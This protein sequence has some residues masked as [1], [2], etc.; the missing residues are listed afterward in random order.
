MDDYLISG[1]IFAKNRNECMQELNRRLN[2]LSLTEKQK[3][4]MIKGEEVILELL[5]RTNKSWGSRCI[6]SNITDPLALLKPKKLTL[7]ELMIVIDEVYCIIEENHRSFSYQSVDVLMAIIGE[8]KKK[9]PY[10]SELLT[11]LKKIGLNKK[12]IRAFIESEQ[13]I[14]AQSRWG[15]KNDYSKKKKTLIK[16]FRVFIFIKKLLQ[17]LEFN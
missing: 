2:L 13:L 3:A 6:I 9:S 10:Y 12:Q 5:R 14:I 16:L 4:K 1:L 17:K 7:S 11:R 15:K 8:S